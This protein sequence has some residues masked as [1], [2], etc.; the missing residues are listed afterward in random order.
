MT[1]LEAEAQIAAAGALLDEAEAVL[2][3]SSTESSGEL[4]PGGSSSSVDRE[5]CEAHAAAGQQVC[6][7]CF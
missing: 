7:L 6:S 3:G 2:G 5:D 4:P 1:Q